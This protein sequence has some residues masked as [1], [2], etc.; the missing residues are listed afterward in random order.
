M[1]MQTQK[2]MSS[3]GAKL[4]PGVMGYSMGRW[5]RAL[6]RRGSEISDSYLL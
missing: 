4:G 5:R 3:I 1:E 6:R 2:L